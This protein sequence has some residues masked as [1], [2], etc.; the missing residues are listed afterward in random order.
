MFYLFYLL[1]ACKETIEPNGVWEI[2]VTGTGSDNPCVDST[3]GF[4]KTYEYALYFDGSFVEIK[5]DGESFATGEQR[6]G[7]SLEYTS[8]VYFEE[9]D[10]GIFRWQIEGEAEVEGAAGGCDAV[11]DHLDWFGTE[12]LKVVSS[13][14]ESI[15]KGC[16]YNMDVQGTVVY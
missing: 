5:V 7:C 13:E 10:N 11:P 8:G 15:E 2:T 16:T 9:S 4:E 3:E 12:T 1:F 14:N 6:D